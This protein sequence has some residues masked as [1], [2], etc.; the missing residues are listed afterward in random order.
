MPH[1]VAAETGEELPQAAGVDG[2]EDGA[3]VA[4]ESCVG[5]GEKKREIRSN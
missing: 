3:A 4:E 1:M 5:T 2:V